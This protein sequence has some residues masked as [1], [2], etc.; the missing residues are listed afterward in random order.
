MVAYLITL[1][2]ESL[3]TA[4]AKKTDNCPHALSNGNIP[5][6]GGNVYAALNLLHQVK[7][8]KLSAE[9]AFEHADYY[10]SACS[11]QISQGQA[12]ANRIKAR[13]QERLQTWG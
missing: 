10:W 13:L 7:R 1:E 12:Q 4:A 8:L 2:Y 11:P 3:E 5:G 6:A 9:K